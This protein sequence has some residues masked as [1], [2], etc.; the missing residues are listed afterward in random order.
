VKAAAFIPSKIISERS[1]EIIYRGIEGLTEMDIYYKGVW[2]M[3]DDFTGAEWDEFENFE[4]LVE[5]ESDYAEF[6]AAEAD[7]MAKRM[8]TDPDY[9][10][11]IVGWF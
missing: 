4:D 8:M 11:K 6:V 3:M 7:E 2:I 10:D 1:E 5:R 9:Y